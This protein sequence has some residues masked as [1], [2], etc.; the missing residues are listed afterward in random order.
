MFW[1][2]LLSSP[3]ALRVTDVHLLQ[4]PGT[5]P[6]WPTSFWIGLCPCWWVLSVIMQA[7][8]MSLVTGVLVGRAVEMGFLVA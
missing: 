6:H 8:S 7:P 1:V 3:Q 5:S 2:P 4:A